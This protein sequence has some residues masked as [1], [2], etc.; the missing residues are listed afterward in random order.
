[1]SFYWSHDIA[2]QRLSNERSYK[3]ILRAENEVFSFKNYVHEALNA[4]NEVFLQT[5]FLLFF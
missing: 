4:E 2:L 1:M 5:V 3:F